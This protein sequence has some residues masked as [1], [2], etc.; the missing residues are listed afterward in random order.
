MCALSP[1]VLITLPTRLL[2]HLPFPSH[3]TSFP[4]SSSSTVELGARVTATQTHTHKADFE[5]A[6]PAV[7]EGTATATATANA[8]S[9]QRGSSRRW[10]GNGG[11]TN[12]V[13]S[14]GRVFLPL[15]STSLSISLQSTL[16]S[17]AYPTPG[18]L[19]LVASRGKQGLAI[20]RRGE[21]SSSL[22]RMAIEAAA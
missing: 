6:A 1:V 22:V 3:C 7:A 15:T 21:S 13:A 12:G 2:A 9:E 8:F 4:T 5:R 20:D 17:V 11:S 18:F 16:R 14:R 19:C 10:I